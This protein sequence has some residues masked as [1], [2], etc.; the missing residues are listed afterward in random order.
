MQTES[1]DGRRPV[2]LMMVDWA[3]AGRGRE[4]AERDEECGRDGGTQV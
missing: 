4:C 3:V 2:I 1:A